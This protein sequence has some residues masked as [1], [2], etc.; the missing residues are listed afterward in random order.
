MSHTHVVHNY[1]I[2]YR[3]WG[4]RVN[5]I[6]NVT[7]IINDTKYFSPGSLLTQQPP[8]L[9]WHSRPSPKASNVASYRCYSLLTIRKWP[10]RTLHSNNG[11]LSRG[12]TATL[13]S[14][15][16]SARVLLILFF[17]CLSLWC[18]VSLFWCPLLTLEIRNTEF[19]WNKC[20][21]NIFDI[22]C[23]PRRQECAHWLQGW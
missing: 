13:W 22:A 17:L 21:K 11:L 9:M 8:Q 16:I 7:V 3:T 4:V 15:L 14:S 10:W 5:I 2:E 18:W 12:R 19:F 20:D 23:K 6:S 1:L